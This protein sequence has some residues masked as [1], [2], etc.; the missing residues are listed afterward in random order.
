MSSLYI[1]DEYKEGFTS[2]GTLDHENFAKL[3]RLLNEAGPATS[4]STLIANVSA[5]FDEAV[6]N[7]IVSILEAVTELDEYRSSGDLDV[8]DI[9][10]QSYKAILELETVKTDEDAQ[11]IYERLKQL[12]N[13]DSNIAITSKISDLKADYE[14][15]FLHSR[16]VNDVR[17]IFGEDCSKNPKG[18]LITH[19]LKIAYR[20]IEGFKEI[21]L[22]LDM[23][24]VLQIFEQINRTIYKSNSLEKM[25]RDLGIN[26]Y[27]ESQEED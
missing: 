1:P 13:A 12:I 22:S 17:P 26:Y 24:D 7:H 5:K 27:T 9:I 23:N 19:N 15:I 14:K 11:Q 3:I 6:K 20:D 4:S 16:I 8:E 10:E 25:F 2:L 21:Y 18:M